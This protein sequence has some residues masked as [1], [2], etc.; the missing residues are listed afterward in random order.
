MS[1]EVAN[2]ISSLESTHSS[3]RMTKAS[4]KERGKG[5]GKGKGRPPGKQGETSEDR[6]DVPDEEEGSG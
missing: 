5:T 1:L 4:S 3:R 2:S 6:D